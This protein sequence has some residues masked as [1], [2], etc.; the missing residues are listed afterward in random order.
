MKKHVSKETLTVVHRLLD[1][2]DTSVTLATLSKASKALGSPLF[3][4]L[5]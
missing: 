1:P 3:R 5:R 4:V 2:G